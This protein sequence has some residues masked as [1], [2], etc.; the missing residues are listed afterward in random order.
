[1]SLA[2]MLA[3]GALQAPQLE[4]AQ[5]PVQ[6]PVLDD[7]PVTT[8]Q[9]AIQ[10][11]LA[12]RAVD[13]PRAAPGTHAR[14]RDSPLPPLDEVGAW[15]RARRGSAPGPRAGVAALGSQSGSAPATLMLGSLYFRLR[16]YEDTVEVYERFLLHA[17]EALVRTRHLGH[18]LYSLGHYERARIHYARVLAVKPDAGGLRG[19]T[20]AQAL[21]G[22]GLSL[23]QLGDLQSARAK[24]ESALTDAPRDADTHLALAQVLDELDEVEAA[25]REARRARVLAPFD[26][27]AAFLLS[28]LLED[29]GRQQ[30]AREARASFERLAPIVAQIKDLE[31]RLQHRPET[32]RRS[33]NWPSTKPRSETSRVSVR[34]WGDWASRCLRDSE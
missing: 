24:L 6:V 33:S 17:P 12:Q 4:S 27:R 10:D 23:R 19:I 14:W 21:R 20:R 28:T 18:A 11:P 15:R 32:A 7:T 5:V 9:P 29:L 25:A 13:L 16:R 3:L 34:P 30:E 8:K 2:F 22:L 31:L 1:M 26:P